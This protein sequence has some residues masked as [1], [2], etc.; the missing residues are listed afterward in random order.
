MDL[1]W[2]KAQGVILFGMLCTFVWFIFKRIEIATTRVNAQSQ[3][4][5]DISK[6]E[7]KIDSLKKELDICEDKMTRLMGEHKSDC[8]KNNERLERMMQT[9]SDLIIKNNK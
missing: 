6:N 5:L 3:M 9:L 8:E 4:R 2:I 7:Y 1:D